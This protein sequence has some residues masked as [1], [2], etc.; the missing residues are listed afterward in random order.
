MKFADATSITGT[1][2]NHFLPSPPTPVTSSMQIDTTVPV[3]TP[4]LVHP[5]AE[6]T[7][8]TVTSE[9]LPIVPPIPASSFTTSP[10]LP[11]TSTTSI[12]ESTTY[13][14]LPVTSTTSTP[15]STTYPELPVTSTTSTPESTTYPELPVTSTASTP[16]STT[17]PKLPV[18]STTST[19]ELHEASEGSVSNRYSTAGNR[20]VSL[21]LLGTYIQ[22]ITNHAA[23]CGHGLQFLGESKRIGLCSVLVSRCYKCKQS[24][25]T[26][27]SECVK[28]QEKGHYSTNLGA[29]LGQVSTGGGG[30]HLEEQLSSMNIPSLS[31]HTFVSI[32]RSLGTA[33]EDI[34]TK[35]LLSAG[36]EEREHA[37]TN[38]KFFE[39][40][41]ACTVVV[42]AGWSKRS[43][44][45]SYNAN[46]GVGVIFGAHSKKLLYIGIH[47]KYCSTC[48]VAQRSSD[49]IPPHKC[50]KNWSQSSCAMESDIIVEGFRC[51]E[52]MHG[53][54]YMWMIGDGDSSVY[55]SVCIGVP[56]GRFVQKVECTNHAVKCYRSALEKL[57]KENTHFSGRKGLTAGKIRHLSKGMKCAIKHHSATGDFVALRADLRNCP[58]HCFGDHRQCNSSFCKNVGECSMGKTYYTYTGTKYT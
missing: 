52:R 28:F 23:V 25:K 7:W 30:D 15:E 39:G 40:V 29:V 56:Y 1:I 35:E 51:S 10:E 50:Y 57:A 11:V 21:T 55:S 3:I 18:T 49:T 38:N 17:Y 53:L 2:T 5:L 14:E 43:H 16:E 33:F 26:Y 4:P 19:P 48:S 8:P 22:E 32:E 41:P 31:P 12:P 27:T 58:R 9:L 6:L 37:I 45:H 54:R 46:S 24:F 36:R 47:N 13:P 20:I 42:D 34:V 44:K